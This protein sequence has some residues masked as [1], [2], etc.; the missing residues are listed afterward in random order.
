MANGFCKDVM[1]HLD[2][3]D[4]MNYPGKKATHQ[5]FLEALLNQPDRPT[6]LQ[7]LG[8]G[9]GHNKSVYVKYKVRSV[10]SQ[11]S[12]NLPACEINIVNAYKEKLVTLPYAASIAVHFN[13]ETVRQYCSE[14]SRMVRLGV[15]SAG[16]MMA[17]NEVLD[18]IQSAA[19]GLYA[20][21]E[22]KLTT[23]QSL[24]WGK[25]IVGGATLTNLNIPLNGTNNNLQQNIGKLLADA[26]MNEFC[27]APFI[28][29]NGNFHNFHVNRMAGA[30]SFNQA[31]VNM[32]AMA[33]ELGYSFHLSAK[34]ATTWGDNRIGVFSPGS[35][36]FLQYN[37]NVGEA[38]TGWR[39]DTFYTRFV[40]NRQ[41]CWAPGGYQNLEFDMDI[42]YVN[43]ATSIRNDYT[44]VTSTT[45]RGWIVTL[46][47]S[48]GLF[49]TPTDAYDGA[50]VLAGSNGTLQ[51]EVSNA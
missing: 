33:A 43:C 18:G 39:G 40:D 32:A 25:N 50:D 41:Q 31:G 5:G 8:Y 13:D 26:E 10:E 1:T 2:M 16:Q 4:G 47:T 28:V 46:S 29:G 24:A 9:D 38:F 3:V 45:Q 34:T 35:V 20:F 44:G 19:N 22:T 14:V 23:A 51:Y 27:G 48:F 17:M 12:D 21:M 37:R 7:A 6:I 36:H 11:V 30:Y 15:S 42:R 49:S